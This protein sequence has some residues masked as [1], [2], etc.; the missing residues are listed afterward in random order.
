MKNE[1][2]KLTKQSLA[3]SLGDFINYFINF[4]LF[5]VYI[6]MLTPT[7]LG[8]LLLVSLFGT[9]M[10]MLL[11]LGLNDGF[12]RLYFD[13]TD[14]AQKRQL[15][16]SVYWGLIFVNAA[17]F[18]PL[19]FFIDRI[20][21]IFLRSP[22]FGSWEFAHMVSMYS[23]LFT[24]M[25]ISSCVRSFLNVP[26]TLLRTEQKARHF[27]GISI[28]RFFTNMILKV[29]FVVAF[30]WNIHGIV[31]VDLITSLFF[32]VSFMPLVWRKVSM[33]FN[34]AMMK[35]LLKFG[36]PKVPHNMAH[37]LLNQADR[38][39]LG[40]VS[41]HVAIGI[42]GVGYTIGMALKFFSYAF[43]MAWTP[44]SYKIHKEESAPLRIARLSTYN[45]MLQLFSAV[46]ISTFA[47][48]LLETFDYLLKIKQE[49]FLALPVVPLVAYAYVFQAA[50]FLTNVGISIAKK[51]K[52]YPVITGTSLVINIG[53]NLLLIPK[54]GIV[55]AAITA[56]ISYATMALLALYFGQKFYRVPWEWKRLGLLFGLCIG[57]TAA[58]QLL[59]QF[60]FFVRVPLKTVVVGLLPVL[61]WKSGFF[62]PEEREYL[63]GLVRKAKR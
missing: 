16:G 45:M 12:M 43:N 13:Y 38:F 34:P 6:K 37:H 31:M 56:N 24:M 63:T 3:Y 53:F 40:K 21:V 62:L 15:L 42:Y 47:L 55:G 50:Y 48:E 60:E 30:K 52:Y 17:L 19:Y 39:I 27:A 44:H 9:L 14:P 5:P 46:L 32:T 35:E 2:K 41:G 22:E 51:T 28:V 29:I 26:Y 11:R 4:L 49:W 20:S 61:L 58:T 23:P 18:I 7:E 33:K 8:I 25:L 36:L 57:T 1:V 54:F 10:R 59:S